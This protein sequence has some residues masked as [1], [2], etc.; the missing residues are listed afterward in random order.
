M[1]SSQLKSERQISG[2]LTH[3]WNINIPPKYF[4]CEK[5]EGLKLELSQ[6]KIMVTEVIGERVEAMRE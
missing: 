6:K 1:L 2:N 4:L 3:L 5:I